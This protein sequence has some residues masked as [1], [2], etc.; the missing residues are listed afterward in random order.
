MMPVKG[1]ARMNHS[2]TMLLQRLQTTV[3]ASQVTFTR[4]ELN[5]LIRVL[6]AY[7]A[8]P[9]ASLIITTRDSGRSA[10]LLTMAGVRKKAAD[11][12]ARRAIYPAVPS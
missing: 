7:T 5:I 12:T 6:S 8:T 3:P 11:G 1:T 4:D 9:A 2:L 10:M